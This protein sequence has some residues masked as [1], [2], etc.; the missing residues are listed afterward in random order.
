[1]DALLTS[2]DDAVRSPFAPYGFSG[3]MLGAAIVFFAYIGFDSIS[4]HSEEAIRP[5]RDVPIGILASLVFCTILYIAVSAVITGMVPYPKI[6]QNTAIASAFSDKAAEPGQANNF[7]LNISAVL[8]S[9]GGLAGMTSVLLITFLSQA[10][11]F[12]AMARDG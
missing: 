3:I 11:I 1:L 5:Q 2:I 10:R 4:T 9:A 6:D 8:I 12:L 7:L